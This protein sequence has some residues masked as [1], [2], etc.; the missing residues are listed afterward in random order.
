MTQDLTLDE[1]RSLLAPG[2]AANAAFDGWSDAARDMA[3]DA[4][5]IDRDVA[6]LAFEEGPVDMIDAWFADIDVAMLE[7][8]PPERLSA[9]KIRARIAALIEARLQATAADRE[10]LRRA[11]AIL[12]LPQ[13]LT[14]AGR[15]G[16]RTVDTIW[17]AAG[18]VAT[19][20]N[21]Y[22]KRTIL[23]GVY[24]A[25]V[26]V[27]LDDDSEGFAETRAFLSRRIDGIM[28]FETAKSGFLKRTEHGF[29]L[30]RFV[31]RLRYPVA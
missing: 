17:R 12:A 21:H 1:I 19:D 7:S 8:V 18:D 5:G 13:N 22:T 28:R 2:I 6:A 24:A 31:G 30:S 9:M 26:T 3:A 4:A 11:L 29:S 14:K 16:W 15:L 10:S 23:L 27:F 25:T 20:Y